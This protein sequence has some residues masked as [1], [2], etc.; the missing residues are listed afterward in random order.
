MGYHQPAQPPAQ[1][2]LNGYVARYNEQSYHSGVNWVTPKSRFD[3][4]EE[5]VLQARK[6]VLERA[7]ARHP[8]RCIRGCV[9]DC[10]PAEPFLFMF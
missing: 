2:W 4:T 8:D 10:T 9:W 1:Q 3:G 7:R 6:E 5:A